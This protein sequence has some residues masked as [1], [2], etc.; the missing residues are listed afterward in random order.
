MARLESPLRTTST[1]PLMEPPSNVARR[2]HVAVL[3]WGTG[4]ACTLAREHASAAIKNESIVWQRA[5]T[6]RCLCVPCRV[7]SS[8][9][10]ELTSIV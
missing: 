7:R 5:S 8:S 1:E 3:I 10:P 6:R 4:T 2:T 9:L